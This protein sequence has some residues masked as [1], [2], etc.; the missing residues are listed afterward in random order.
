MATFVGIAY[1]CPTPS[2]V[3]LTAQKLRIPVKVVKKV[4][5]FKELPFL[6]KAEAI[7]E[8]NGVAAEVELF[9]TADGK[10]FVPFVGKVVYEPS[11]EK[12]IKKITIVSIRNE[13]TSFTLGYVTNDLKYYIPALIP[14]V[15]GN[16]TSVGNETEE[17]TP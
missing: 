12:G 13:T 17:K 14:M 4:E 6:C 7:V 11:G 5:P 1:A 16:Q 8:Q 3:L 9:T 10:Y 15:G 2:E